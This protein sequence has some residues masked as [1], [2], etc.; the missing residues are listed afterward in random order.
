VFEARNL[1]DAVASLAEDLARMVFR[2]AVTEPLA[3]AITV[4]IGRFFGPEAAAGAVLD[5]GRI[6]PFAAGGI[7]DRPTLFPL[8][9]G[10]GLMGEAGPEAIMPLRR[11][12]DGR[13]GVEARGGERPVNVTVRIIDQRS[14]DDPPLEVSQRQAANGD[15]IVDAIVRRT[16]FGMARRGELDALMN[17]YGARRVPQ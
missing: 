4:G 13:L 11:L 6:I 14:I 1:Q 16:L 8:A 12:P 10:A 2:Q 9:G 3:K 17:T 15:A 5:R 7:V